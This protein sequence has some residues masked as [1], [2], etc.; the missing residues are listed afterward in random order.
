M[1]A[2][3]CGAAPDLVRHDYAA[4]AAEYLILAAAFA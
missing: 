3:P 2:T 1:R 4:A